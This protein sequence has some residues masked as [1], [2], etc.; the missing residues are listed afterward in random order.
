MPNPK[1]GIFW[2]YKGKVIFTHAVSVED[3]FLYG[4]AVTGT[5]DHA[6]YWEEL[7]K[8]GKLNVLDESLREEY[9]SIA[10]GRVVF[11]KDTGKFSV[12]HGNNMKKTDLHKVGL[13]FNLPEDRTDFEEDLHYCDLTDSEWNK[14][15]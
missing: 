12:Y 4:E 6:E 1:V 3:G 10:R 9:F 7:R 2:F 14:I 11:H 8:D 5:R 13:F 15:F